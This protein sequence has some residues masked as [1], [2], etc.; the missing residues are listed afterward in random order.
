MVILAN[1][2]AQSLIYSHNLTSLSAK[3]GIRN[4]FA[5]VEEDIPKAH[6]YSDKSKLP[7]IV[8]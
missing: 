6:L 7:Y 8:E 4:K 1:L 5:R 3:D 2:F